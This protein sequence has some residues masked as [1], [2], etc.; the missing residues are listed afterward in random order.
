MHAEGD[1]AET[2]RAAGT[3]VAW[4]SR[5]TAWALM[6][7]SSLQ[8]T[9]NRRC[10]VFL[11]FADKWIPDTKHDLYSFSNTKTSVKRKEKEKAVKL[12]LYNLYRCSIMEFI[13]S[14]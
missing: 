14:Q 5:I 6:P 3:L 7:S 11:L 2:C 8:S 12:V 10:V 4:L 9:V 13:A 1:R